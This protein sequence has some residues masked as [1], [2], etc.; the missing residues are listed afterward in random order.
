MHA[1]VLGAG[2][3]GALVARDL[4][5]D[6][7][8]DVV[9]IDRS[10]DALRALGDAGAIETRTADLADAGAIAREVA[11]A[12]VV[13]GAVP[14]ALGHAALA[15]V[16]QAGRPVVDIAF[17]PE[18]PLQL[19]ALARK[20]GVTA[21]VDCGVAP[22]LSNWFAGRSCAGLEQTESIEILVGGLPFRRY[23]PY[24]YR[25][26]FSP[27][28][29][30]E[31]YT[32]PCRMRE[33]GVEKVVPALSGVEP[34]GFARVGTLEAFN[35]DGLRTLLRTLDVPTLTEKTMRWPGHAERMR[36]LR[37][38]GF[39][40]ER[41]RSFGGVNLAPRT[42]TEALLFEA[43]APL[44]DDEEFT[45]LRVIATGRR[46]GRR[47]RQVWELFDRTDPE[48]GATSMARTTGFPC[49]IVAGMVARGEWSRPGVHPPESLG[50][51]AA[52]TQRLLIELRARG[53]DVR[54]VDD[55]I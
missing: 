42:M 6:A 47:R 54:F 1:V 43:W 15:A 36:M 49:A 13:V 7:G 31:E 2:R 27:T 28:D 46:D 22:G 24:E 38:T 23:W 25:S 20:A 48:S 51:D 50:Q 4:A 30:V 19:D 18:D 26:V 8:F 16:L 14:G 40:D 37:E 12:D 34:V 21:V 32:R 55:E 35:T 41:P 29:V 33:G 52:L 3:V 10:D 11:G 9:A 53:V 45:V 39:F 17:A 44:D 5:S